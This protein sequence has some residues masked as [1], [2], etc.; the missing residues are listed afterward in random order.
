MN[1]GKLLKAKDVN[2]M[3]FF[4]ILGPV[5]LNGISFFT[6]PIFTRALGT[7][8]YG[9]ASL[10]VTWVQICTTV[11]GLQTSGTISTAV[12]HFPKESQNAYRSSVLTISLCSLTVVGVLAAV[13]LKP[14]RV[15]T[16]FGTFVIVLLVLHSFG[17]YAVNFASS[18][19]IYEKESY[20]NFLVTVTT[21][22][23]TVVVSLVLIEKVFP[24]QTNYLGRIVGLAIPNIT[25]GFLL[26]AVTIAKGKTGFHK[27]YWR[28]CFPLCL[29]LVFH[30]LSQTV[31]AQTDK[32]M[33]KAFTDDSTV[34]IYSLAV[35]VAH[36]LVIVWSALNNTWLPVYYDDMQAGDHDAILKRS[37]NYIFLY[38]VLTVGF[39]MVAPEIIKLFASADFWPCIE[40][41]PF[42]T[43]GSYML[44]LYSFPVNFQFFYQ[45]SVHIAV[46]TFLAAIVNMVL[47][48]FLI[49]RFGAKGA[50]LATLCAYAALFAFHQ[51]I[52]KYAVKA[53][54]PFGI[55]SFYK[56][57]LGVAAA[58]ALYDLLIDLWYIRWGLGVFL[59]AIL[60]YRTVKR[61]SIF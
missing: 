37:Q 55:K 42:L 50:A 19:F 6:V 40:Y 56:S 10:Y 1:I 29:P 27:T 22:V 30:G 59:G 2:T 28:Y 33:L 45:K 44:F 25:V 31:L 4:N 5:L 54:Y 12:V 32:V 18:V 43:A 26:A 21:A 38:T 13:F 35:T 46:G 11:I 51:C 58:L 49:R 60:L 41:L 3:A 8:N 24:P 23:L 34:G 57:I 15:A 16:G 39:L 7:A 61:K 53:P 14:I 36:I 9:V 47:N 52:A 20:K 17:A 48:Y